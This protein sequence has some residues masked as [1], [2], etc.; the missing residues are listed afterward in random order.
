MEI[1]CTLPNLR[2][3]RFAVRSLCLE[4]AC[5][6]AK[7]RTEKR[8]KGRISDKLLLPKFRDSQ[9]ENMLSPRGSIILVTSIRG[10]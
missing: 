7:V 8:Y 9:P 6:P 4:P 1:L 5:E 3:P 2:A 10:Y